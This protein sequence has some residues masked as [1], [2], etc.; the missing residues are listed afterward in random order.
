MEAFAKRLRELRES[1]GYTQKQ[2]A[3][4]LHI[5]QQSYARYE[6]D[7]GEPSLTTLVKLSQLFEVSVDYLL[8]ISDT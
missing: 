1:Y 5:C 2:V 8:G 7:T 3:E 6:I 4:K